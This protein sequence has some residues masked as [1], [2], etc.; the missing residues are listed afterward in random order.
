MSGQTSTSKN[1][2]ILLQQQIPWRRESQTIKIAI[3]SIVHWR[4]NW[5]F[6]SLQYTLILCYTFWQYIFFYIIIFISYYIMVI[7]YYILLYHI[8]LYVWMSWVRAVAAGSYLTGNCVS[9][10]LTAYEIW[11]LIEFRYPSSCVGKFVMLSV[12]C[13]TQLPWP[14]ERSTV[15]VFYSMYLVQREK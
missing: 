3:I 14:L 1:K 9:V 13:T 2:V 7:S 5:Y 10:K 12:V 6:R 8:I 11:G 4:T 15:K